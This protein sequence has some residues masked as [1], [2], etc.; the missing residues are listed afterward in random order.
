M[1]N[2]EYSNLSL[3]REERRN[4][5]R[6]RVQLWPSAKF[7]IATKKRPEENR[8]NCNFFFLMKILLPELCCF[9][10]RLF[11]KLTQIEFYSNCENITGIH[12]LPCVLIGSQI[13]RFISRMVFK[14]LSSR[15]SLAGICC[16]TLEKPDF[17]IT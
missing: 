4:K 1:C 2:T 9:S 14:K 3:Q 16:L 12:K 8:K 11:R 15:L 6:A 10:L 5:E 7:S 13:F 17:R